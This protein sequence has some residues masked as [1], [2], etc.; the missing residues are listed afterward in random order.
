[1]E[2]KSPSNEGRVQIYELLENLQKHNRLYR[3][4]RPVISDVEYDQLVDKLHA[5][6]P[7]NDWFTHPE[8]APVGAERKCRLPMP[9]KSLN[10]VKSLADIKQWLRSLAIPDNAELVIMPKYDGVSWLVDETNSIAYSRGGAE[11]EGQDCSAH[12]RVGDFKN[13]LKPNWVFNEN[14]GSTIMSYQFTF[15]EL[16]FSCENWEGHFADQISQYTGEKYKSPR[17]TVAGLINRDEADRRLVLTSF[18]RYGVGE[19]DLDAYDKYSTILSDLSRIYYQDN[20]S[21]VMT[22]QEIDEDKLAALFKKWRKQFYIDGL[23]IYLNDINLWRT[24]GRQQTSGNPLYAIAYK[25]PDFTESFE[26]R[27]RDITYQISK[28]GAL[29]PVVNIDAV[30]T[31]DCIMENPTGYNAGWLRQHEIGIGS[32]ILVTRSGGVIPKI[33]EATIP[34]TYIPPSKC[35]ECG[36]PVEF[37]ENMTELYCTN[38]SC[39]GRILSKIIHFFE[40]VGVDDM[41]DETFAKIFKA[42]HTTIRSFLDITPRELFQIDGFGDAIVNNIIKQMAKIKEGV[43]LA[44]LMH[45]SDC[46]KGIGKV[47]AQKLLDEMDC[48][49]LEL[50]CSGQYIRQSDTF[51]EDGKSPK[52]SVTMQNFYLGYFPFMQF[53]KDI[54]IPY[55][56][57]QS[58]E[59][60]GTKYAGFSVCFSGVRDKSLEDEIIRQ[61]GKIA[62]GVSKTTTHLV[63]KDPDGVSSKI[64]KAKNL[65]IPILTIESFKEL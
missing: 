47:K 8:P 30:D 37:D 52:L 32:Q 14:K 64:N 16:L 21:V 26:T 9:M 45:A 60:I 46:F 4:G 29:K 11:N 53:L 40:T 15:G 5:L 58:T 39:P 56:L 12:F 23:V 44:I 59:T 7:N 57:P 36:S 17:N 61:G 18:V 31:G 10:K 33:L 27:V 1:M 3:E 41:G 43:D 51:V 13:L 35:P 2:T 34:V 42:G 50:F 48:N 49:S 19:H 25:H 65:S 28:A 63:V 24:I 6:D 20:L 22:V 62:S 55:I 38:L 54:G